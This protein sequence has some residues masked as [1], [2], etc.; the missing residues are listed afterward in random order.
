MGPPLTGLASR[1]LIAGKL[2]NT[3]DNLVLW[4]RHPKDVKPLTAMPDL[5]VNEPHARD[6]AAYLVTL[7]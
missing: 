2:V 4:L 3:P 7:L 1:S 5:G 6:M